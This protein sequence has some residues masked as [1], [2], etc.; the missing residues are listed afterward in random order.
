MAGGGH[1]G[2]RI[3]RRSVTTLGRIGPSSVEHRRS[4]AAGPGRGKAPGHGLG[5]A[6]FVALC[7]LLLRYVWDAYHDPLVKNGE[8]R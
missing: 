7:S 4:S 6:P 3:D 8:F 5:R 2:V 1:P